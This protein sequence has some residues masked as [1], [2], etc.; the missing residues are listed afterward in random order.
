MDRNFIE[1]RWH[2][3]GA[4]LYNNEHERAVDVLD[5][6]LVIAKKN[7]DKYAIGG[8]KNAFGI[9]Y[10]NW[11][12]YEQSIQNFEE[13]LEIRVEEKNLQEEAIK[14]EKIKDKKVLRDMFK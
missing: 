13:A 11:V 7:N 10:Q 4:L 2:Y 1:P 5:D 14:D 3:A 9:I 6:A 8:I 12:R